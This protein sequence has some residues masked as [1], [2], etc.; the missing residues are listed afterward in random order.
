MSAECPD[1]FSMSNKC[2]LQYLFTDSVFLLAK[3]VLNAY[4]QRMRALYV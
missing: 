3:F 1:L 2:R 4:Q